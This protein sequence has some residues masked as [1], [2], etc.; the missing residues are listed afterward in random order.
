[1]ELINALTPLDAVSQRTAEQIVLMLAP[2]A[3]QRAVQWWT[4]L[5]HTDDVHYHPLPQRDADAIM[6]SSIDL[7][8]QIGGKMRGTVSLQP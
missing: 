7:P 3:T 4:Q 6:A 2:F 5:G 1:M 8:V